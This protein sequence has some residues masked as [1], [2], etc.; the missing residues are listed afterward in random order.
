MREYWAKEVKFS[1]TLYLNISGEEQF[2]NSKSTKFCPG[3][4]V[5]FSLSLIN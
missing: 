1:E 4:W 3:K 2:Y 5:K